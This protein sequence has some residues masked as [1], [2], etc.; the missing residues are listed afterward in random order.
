M[1]NGYIFD[2]E[3]ELLFFSCLEFRSFVIFHLLYVLIVL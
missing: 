1:F 2:L 3:V